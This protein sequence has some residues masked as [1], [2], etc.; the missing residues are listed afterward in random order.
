M[1]T[2]AKRI[3][4]ETEARLERLLGSRER[5]VAAWKKVQAREAHQ[6]EVLASLQQRR[7]DRLYASPQFRNDLDA[8]RKKWLHKGFI[9]VTIA[10][11]PIVVKGVRI[12]AAD[13]F[14]MAFCALKNA[15]AALLP[16]RPAPLSVYTFFVF[17]S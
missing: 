9:P 1:A 12:E 13:E 8:F 17:A 16:A 2:K 6:R 4:K 15:G 3:E 7:A 11:R 14:R 10:D 5:W